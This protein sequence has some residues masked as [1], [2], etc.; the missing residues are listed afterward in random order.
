MDA[1]RCGAPVGLAK[2]DEGP[3]FN[4]GAMGANFALARL[5]VPPHN[6]RM[7][8]SKSKARFDTV[9]T[10]DGQWSVRV[11]LPGGGRSQID[12]FR[13]ESEARRWI[14]AQSAAWL[15]MHEGGKYA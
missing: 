1:L 12:D 8:P 7:A 15:K 4:Q 9:E 13:T 11:M 14:K 2:S 10:K 3:A 6:E 5:S